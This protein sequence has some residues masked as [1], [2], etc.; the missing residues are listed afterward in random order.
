MIRPMTI[1][2]ITEVQRIA[3]LS[4]EHT[5]KNIIPTTIQ[6]N[7]LNY[8]YSNSMLEKRL[9]KT[10]MFI[11]QINNKTIGFASFTAKDEDGDA[12]LTAMY[13][14]PEY[15]KQGFGKKLLQ[16]GLEFL[17]NANQIFVYVE[18]ENHNGRQF[19]EHCGFEFIEE[20]EELFDNYSLN[21]CK[22][23]YILQSK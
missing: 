10:I 18:S 1:N 13:L 22:Y 6:T 17:H 3:K 21:T 4:W 2:D 23:V 9:E 14:L 8:F 19:Y 5:Y 20:F 11:A 15:Q 16:K 7:Y 12:E